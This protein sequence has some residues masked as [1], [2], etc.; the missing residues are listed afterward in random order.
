MKPIF[1][2]II[3][4]F[5]NQVLLVHN[6]QRGGWE[7]PGGNLESSDL[8]SE[9]GFQ[10]LHVYNLLKGAHREYT[11]ETESTEKEIQEIAEGKVKGLYYNS[12]TGTLFILIKAK[13][14]FLERTVRF[15][16]GID[17]AKEFNFENLPELS[18]PSDKAVL[19]EIKK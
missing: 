6:K 14:S 16:G 7:F 4:R 10:N 8:I 19:L 12:D 11:E 15:D 1:V 13:N 17:Y 3:R 9:H 5:Q 18:F 2:C